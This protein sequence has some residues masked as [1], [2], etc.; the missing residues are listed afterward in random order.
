MSEQIMA[1][2]LT[3]GVFLLMAAWVPFLELLQHAVRR[4][5]KARMANLSRGQILDADHR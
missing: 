3:L 2:L 1:L 4:S 5:S